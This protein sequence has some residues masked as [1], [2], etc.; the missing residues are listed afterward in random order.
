VLRRALLNLKRIA[1]FGLDPGYY[2]TLLPP[3]GRGL[4]V[5]GQG[6]ARPRARPV[7]EVV[8]LLGDRPSVTKAI[9]GASLQDIT[10]VEPATK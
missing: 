5:A 7:T 6:P 8:V 2:T 1:R 4:A 10:L 9:A 3:G